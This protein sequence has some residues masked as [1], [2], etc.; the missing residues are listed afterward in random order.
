MN[1]ALNLQTFGAV[2][3]LL[4][5]VSAELAA[6]FL[7]LHPGSALGWSLNMGLFRV[8]EQAR[9]DPSPLRFLFSPISLSVALAALLLVVAA[10][11]FR[12]RLAIALAANLSFAF[13]IALAHAAFGASGLPTTASLGPVA[14]SPDASI[15]LGLLLLGSF[16]AF[17]T[18]HV[19]F[20]K[21]IMSER[22]SRR[23]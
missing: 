22:A 6:R 9:A 16:A 7:M 4:A 11:A 20:F 12:L 1:Q 5:F 14:A 15:L 13:V 19:S 17:A 18:S 2:L 23:G 3:V 10:R 8:F 21:A